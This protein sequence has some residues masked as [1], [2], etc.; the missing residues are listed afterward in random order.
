VG[1]LVLSAAAQ[2]SEQLLLQLVGKRVGEERRQ[3][4]SVVLE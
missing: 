2:V 1:H 3:V 4:R